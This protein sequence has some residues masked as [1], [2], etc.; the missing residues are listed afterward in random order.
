MHADHAAHTSPGR[1]TP[2]MPDTTPGPLA[3]IR[4]LD[5]ATSRAEL[6]GR[7][8]ADLGAEVT[9]VEPPG[10]VDAR[11]RPPFDESHGPRHGESLYWAALGL[12]KRSIVLDLDRPA[13]RDALVRLAADADVLV[14]SFDPG[15]LDALGLGYAALSTAHPGLV[16]VSV[17]PYGQAGPTAG[18]PASELTLEAAGGRLSLQGDRDRAPLPIGYPQAAFHAGAQAAADAVIA[19]N[20]R[21]LSGRGQHLDTSMQ[22]AMVWTLMDGT[23]YP[24][25]TG[26]DPPGSDDDRARWAE[27][28]RVGPGAAVPCADGYVI[29]TL[30]AD[31]LGPAL[32][33][34][35]AANADDGRA[36]LLRATRWATWSADA[37]AGR[38][39][40]DVMREASTLLARLVR[41]STMRELMDW[42]VANDIMLAP[43]Q[44]TRDILDDPQFAARDYWRTVGGYRHPG[45]P[46]RLARTPITLDRPAPALGADQ[47]LV[48]APRRR[49]APPAAPAGVNERRGEAFT[50]LRVADFTWVAAG[51]M[52]AKA[53]A[54]HG[55]TVVKIES[56]TRLDLVRSLPPFKDGMPGA[57]RSHWLSNLNTSKLSLSLNLA[58]DTGRALARRVIDWADVVLEAFTPGTMRRLGLDYE[59]VSAGRDDLIWMSTCLLGQTGPRATFAGYGSHGAALAGFAAITGWPDRPPVGPA[60]PYTDVITPRFGV[61]VLASAIL[62]RR[63][64]GRGQYIDLAQV[65]GALH[66]L[67]P[68]LLDEAVNGRTAGPAGHDSLTA[69]PHGV[70][71]AAGVERYVALAVETTAQWRALRALAPLDAFADPAYDALEA[72]RAARAAIDTALTAWTSALPA[73]VLEAG[74]VEAGIPAS[75]VQRMSDLHADPQLAHRGFFVEFDHPEMGTHPYDGL[76][77]RF[78]AKREQLHSRAPLLGEHT[79]RVLRDLLGLTPEE[80][81]DAAG[82]GA[83]M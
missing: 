21:A 43:V 20:E 30:R 16:Y 68:L 26:R 24:P 56:G 53:L 77:T 15:T 80:I 31:R 71:A 41:A 82:A 63:R 28:Q 17:T 4:V 11:R 25:M 12:G 34:L 10:G 46:A 54:D 58:T 50:G 65:E 5:L 57:N 1:I 67:E 79:E 73:D 39:D 51:P 23:G 69:C 38:I 78:S 13:D 72:R 35:L 22:A 42:A 44:T 60:G 81:A 74:L 7:L 61:P 62:E 6:A 45:P 8:L 83:L 19:L 33:R 36:T 18:W 66:M 40:G 70:Y 14:E 9:K 3:G 2:P 48:D 76:V 32:E 55:A 37:A 27:A 59:T 64:S 29:A 52:T 75:R 47:A 49:G